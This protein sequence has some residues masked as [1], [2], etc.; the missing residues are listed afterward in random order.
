M[1]T[2]I[3]VCRILSSLFVIDL[4]GSSCILSIQGACRVL[5]KPISHFFFVLLLLSAACILRCRSRSRFFFFNS[6]LHTQ[7]T[8]EHRKEQSN[9]SSLK[10][11]REQV[12]LSLVKV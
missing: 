1:L 9:M 10:P 5:S 3:A 6:S 7:Q 11:A 8:S 2:A 12:T 4:F